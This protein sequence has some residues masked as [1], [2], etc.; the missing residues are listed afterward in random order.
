MWGKGL[1][2]LPWRLLTVQA[3]RKEGSGENLHTYFAAAIS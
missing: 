1:I 3:L 2:A